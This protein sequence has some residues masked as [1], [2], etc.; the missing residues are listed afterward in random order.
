R[1]GVVAFGRLQI[2]RAHASGSWRLS[3][4]GTGR[5]GCRL[6]SR[7]CRNPAEANFEFVDEALLRIIHRDP[8]K[9]PR[10]FEK[11]HAAEALAR[12]RRHGWAAVFL[13]PEY[14]T[15]IPV[16]RFDPAFDRDRALK[17]GQCAVF[18][19]IR[20]EFVSD[21]RELMGGLRAKADIASADVHAF[22]QTA[23]LLI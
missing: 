11:N 16:E 6:R 22:R 20:R 4:A 21:Q 13:P 17:V 9:L 15:R 7:R 2:G 18:E 10:R 5:S 3:G 12:R 23:E 1:S 14:E 8:A 19:G